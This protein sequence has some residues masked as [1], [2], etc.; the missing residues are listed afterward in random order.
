HKFASTFEEHQV[1]IQANV[2]VAK[3]Y[4]KVKAV[5][6]QIDEEAQNI[7]KTDISN[8]KPTSIKDLFN[9]IN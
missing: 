3:T 8:Q 1:N 7:M 6:T 9:N 2:G 5:E 4:T